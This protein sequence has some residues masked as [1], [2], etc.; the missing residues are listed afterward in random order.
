MSRTVM[1]NMI[2]HDASR[3]NHQIF[4]IFAEMTLE[5]PFLKKMKF[6]TTSWRKRKELS[7]VLMVL[8]TVFY[9]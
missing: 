5:D 9:C 2:T 3:T 7:Y 1:Q 6:S 4:N 8:E